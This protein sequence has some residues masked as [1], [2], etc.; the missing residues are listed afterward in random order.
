MYEA[1]AA[2]AVLED[3]GH[4][5]EVLP[6]ITEANVNASFHS[7]SDAASSSYVT[8]VDSQN[9]TT[10]YLTGESMARINSVDLVRSK[11][12][13][14]PI[15]EGKLALGKARRA[16]NDMLSLYND[17]L[18]Y[19]VWNKVVFKAKNKSIASCFDLLHIQGVK[20]YLDES[21]SFNLNALKIHTDCFVRAIAFFRA[22][23]VK[24]EYN[25]DL[26]GAMLLGNVDGVKFY[27]ALA[28]AEEMYPCKDKR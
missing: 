23:E 15:Q 16:V 19:E 18:G 9:F 10:Y 25:K 4:Y 13:Q 5:V 3:D 28:K 24:T 20:A 11:G 12:S 22:E 2:T 8:S 26:S 27:R 14:I 21:K 6:P 1:E 17:N 7:I